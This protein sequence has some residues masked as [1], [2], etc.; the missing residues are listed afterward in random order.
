MTYLDT[1][2]DMYPA[3]SWLAW[4]VG[5]ILLVVPLSL[6]V[7]ELSNEHQKNKVMFAAIAG[8]IIGGFLTVSPYVIMERADHKIENLAANIQSKYNVQS[9]VTD[10]PSH[11][12][13]GKKTSQEV[14]VVTP[15]GQTV[16]FVLKQDPKTF[17]PTLLDTAIQSGTAPAGAITVKDITR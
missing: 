5:A 9:V 11:F 7:N 1:M 15:Q 13:V 2:N 6:I 8:F 10:Y 3:W 16:I 17:E 12:L 4:V 14:V